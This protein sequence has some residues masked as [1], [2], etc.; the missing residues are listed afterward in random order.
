MSAEC[1]TP[2]CPGDHVSLYTVHSRHGLILDR[3]DDL[4]LAT[5]MLRIWDDAAFV[6]C[7]GRTVIEEK[8][9]QVGLPDMSRGS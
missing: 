5:S 2:G 4:E 9:R 8:R 1:N 7:D 3:F 6:L